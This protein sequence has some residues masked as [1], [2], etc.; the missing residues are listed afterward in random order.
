MSNLN[1]TGNEAQFNEKVTFLKNVDLQGKLE[2]KGTLTVPPLAQLTIDNL[3]VSNIFGNPETTFSNRVNFL[4]TVSFA[5]ALSFT[6][7]EIRDRLSVGVGGTVLIADSRLNPGK[8][9][10]GSTQPTELLDVGG[11]AKIIDLDLRNLYVAGLSTF[12]GVSSFRDDVFFNG[13]SGITSM[14]FDHGANSLK[15]VTGAKAVFGADG[16]DLEIYHDG[17]HSYIKDIG[18]GDLKIQTNNK[19]TIENDT[20]GVSG[21]ESIARFDAY[22]GATLFWRGEGITGKKFQTTG[23]GVSVLGDLI[24]PDVGGRVSRVGLGTTFPAN[25][26][27]ITELNNAEEGELRLDVKGS[28]SVSR[29]IYDSSGS[30]GDNNYWLRRD[31]LGIKWV[32]LTPAFDEGI[33]IQ[34]EGQFLPTDENQ[35]TIGAAV[36]F[37]T[38]NFVQRNSLGKGTD[39]LR[40]T[41]AFSFSQTIA[42]RTGTLNSGSNT[43]TGI[44]TTGIQIGQFVVPNVADPTSILDVDVKVTAIGTG[45]ITLSKNN[46]SCLLYTSDAADE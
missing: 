26:L 15:F 21:N 44:N 35:Q 38:I 42:N 1:V 31:E 30:P 29:N 4:D 27:S 14:R 7:L 36:S 40:P 39:T 24:V 33:F 8:V 5:E 18:T 22:G 25:P 46:K 16:G 45:Q 34:D 37:S 13:S 43:I 12:V 28:I 2:I 41:A 9:G 10:I 19:V 6:D 20:S 23:I 17:D 32:P 11:N 3:T